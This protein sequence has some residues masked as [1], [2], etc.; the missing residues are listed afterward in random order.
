M[1]GGGDQDVH[2]PVVVEVAVAADAAEVVAGGLAVDL[3]AVGSVQPGQGDRARAADAAAAEDDVGGAGV[4]AGVVLAG[5]ADDDV[6]DAVAVDVAQGRDPDA[7]VVAR[8]LTIDLEAVGSV[9][10]GEVEVAG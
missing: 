8:E 2:G 9:E 5:G 1:E 3:E 7:E 6:V 4:G 10:G